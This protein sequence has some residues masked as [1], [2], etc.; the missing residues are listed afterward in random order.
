M[1]ESVQ[2][3]KSRYAANLASAQQLCTAHGLSKE[4]SQAFPAFSAELSTFEPLVP[5][6]G[7]FNAGKSSLLNAVFLTSVLPVD[8]KPTTAIAGELRPSSDPHVKAICPDGSSERLP[9]ERIT[10]A[11]VDA[12]T[13]IEIHLDSPAFARLGECVLVDMPGTD[14][15]LEAHNRAILNYLRRGAHFLYIIDAEQG[16]IRSDSIA[17]L[18][19]LQ[20]YGK[21]FSVLLNKSD[22]K[23]E[24]AIKEIVQGVREA[25]GEFGS[26]VF[27][28]SCSAR[29]AARAAA[30]GANAEKVPSGSALDDFFA[31][32]RGVD[33]PG[34]FRASVRAGIEVAYASAS[35]EFKT[36]ADSM[37]L[38]T[39][40]IDATIRDLERRGQDMERLFQAERQT[41]QKR[42]S[43][44]AVESVLGELKQALRAEREGL[45][46]LLASKS[47]QQAFAAHINEI[48]RPIFVCAT[49][50]VVEDATRE[51]SESVKRIWQETA[52]PRIASG[53]GSQL[54]ALPPMNANMNE[55]MDAFS[56]INNLLSSSQFNIAFKSLA[57]SLGLM[58]AVVAPWLEVIILFLPEI[59]KGLDALLFGG[60]REEERRSKLL[61]E[62]DGI[63]SSVAAKLR[64][65]TQ[66]TLATA[67]ADISQSAEK[68]YKEELARM[69]AAF[70][71]AK[72]QRASKTGEFEKDKNALS[73]GLARLEALA[74]EALAI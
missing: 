63:I 6:C 31:A 13:H 62:V 20:R 60:A 3:M 66:S 4:A 45:A 46:S 43:S 59:L 11:T 33:M 67:L 48:I 41:L 35:R 17:F 7:C 36:R 61:S 12:Y 68:A 47:G 55:A 8:I 19:E 40:A 21:P 74:V 51:F 10:D 34:H 1:G 9:L 50:K 42:L 71:A 2:S 14:S 72:A 24:S 28:G 30:S 32:L 23:P 73:Q 5:V 37:A 58:T 57:G 39:S 65:Q 27:V 16:T 52:P 26:N 29:T 15:N 56:G 25:L 38:D 70:E 64:P 44:S 69:S 54:G 18:R 49:Q 53:A 22:K